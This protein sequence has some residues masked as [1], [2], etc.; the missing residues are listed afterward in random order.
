MRFVPLTRIVVVS[1]LLA[2]AG[3]LLLANF[4]PSSVSAPRANV[5]GGK[6]TVSPF[7]MMVQAPL[8]L[9]VEQYDSY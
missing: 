5:L 2:A 6:S 8:N 1:I 7:A 3:G 9:P 4:V